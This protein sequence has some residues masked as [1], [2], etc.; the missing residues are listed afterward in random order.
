MFNSVISELLPVEL[1]AWTPFG[2]SCIFKSRGAPEMLHGREEAL[3][4]HACVPRT[5]LG[6]RSCF[7]PGAWHFE[8][9]ISFAYTEG[10]KCDKENKVPKPVV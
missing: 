8:L 6:G 3:A 7:F 1:P 4:E 10:E 5:I 9:E 2:G